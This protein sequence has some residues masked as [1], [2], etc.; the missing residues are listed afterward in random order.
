M[1]RKGTESAEEKP[2]HEGAKSTKREEEEQMFLLPSPCSS[3]LR[4]SN[5]LS[6]FASFT[7][8]RFSPVST[9]V[10]SEVS[11]FCN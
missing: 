4:G 7:F 6:L 3:R 5:S 10:L 11:G 8:L 9:S 2:N 1:N